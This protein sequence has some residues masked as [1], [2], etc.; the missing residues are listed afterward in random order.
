MPAL[1]L[2]AGENVRYMVPHTLRP[3]H[4]ADGDIRVQLR[5]RQPLERPVWVELRSGD[6]LLHRKGERTRVRAR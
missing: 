2:K 1:P 6:K 3:D 4:L 5:V